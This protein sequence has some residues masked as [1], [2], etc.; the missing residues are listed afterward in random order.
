MFNVHSISVFWAP[1]FCSLGEAAGKVNLYIRYIPQWGC[2]G[3]LPSSLTHSK[4]KNLA[5][6]SKSLSCLVNRSSRLSFLPPRGCL[7]RE[8]GSEAQLVTVKRMALDR[9][10]RGGGKA[11]S[12]LSYAT[13]L[14]QGL[15]SRAEH[16]DMSRRGSLGKKKE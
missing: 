13:L 11:E 1:S 2:D 16:L 7:T 15:W 8:V 9:A 3:L 6:P 5:L 10:C 12:L 4:Y 14:Q